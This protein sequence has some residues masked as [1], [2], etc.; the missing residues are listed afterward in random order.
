MITA[1]GLAS[2][3]ALI[4]DH[5]NI[6]HSVARETLE[7]LIERGR[8]IIAVAQSSRLME[9]RDFVEPVCDQGNA[10]NNDEWGTGIG[11]GSLKS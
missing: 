10:V 5:P 4:R 7:A 8:A 11:F 2:L 9:D 6:F 3:E 1:T